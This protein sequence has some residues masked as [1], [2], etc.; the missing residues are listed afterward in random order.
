MKTIVLGIGNPILGDDGVG[1]NVA[2]KLKRCIHGPEI[3]IMEASAGGMG[4]VETILGYDRAILIDAIKKDGKMGEVKRFSV[5]DFSIHSCNPHDVNL[6]TALKIIEKMG[7]GIPDI[8]IVGII[9]GKSSFGEKMSATIAEAVPR[10]VE[11]TM[12]ELQR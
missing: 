10:A 1:I 11:M 12:A 7:A 5:E 4:I 2:R 6:S 8:V 3:K 9:V